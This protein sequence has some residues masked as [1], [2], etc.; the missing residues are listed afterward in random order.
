MLA[1]LR[2]KIEPEVL[3]N[4][5][6]DKLI[7]RSF[8]ND[9]PEGGLY[10][11]NSYFKVLYPYL[12]ELAN[13]LNGQR[14]DL[15]LWAWMI[16]RRFDWTDDARFFDYE[17]ST[18]PNGNGTGKRAI[19]KKFDLFNPDA[20]QKIVGV[21]RELAKK[22][23]QGILIQD[24]LFIRYNEGF[25]NWGKARFTTSTKLPFY[26]NLV[27][28]RDSNFNQDWNRVK[29]NQINKVLE[30]VIA[31]CKQVNP[32]IQIGMNIYYETPFF[33]DRSE[34]WYSHNLREILQTGIDF[35]Y[36]MSYH[37]QMKKEMK[38]GDEQNKAFFKQVVESAY[39]VCGDKLVVKLQLKDWETGDLIPVEEL[40]Q[41]LELVPA[42]VKRVCFM[43][44]GIEDLNHIGQVLGPRSNEAT[45][46][47]V[48]STGE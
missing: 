20:I 28:S 32:K 25:S 26:E 47:A 33:I 11:S 24:D 12:D 30:Q 5:G 6:I 43:P 21:Y 1:D 44:V 38:L 2:G 34:K 4:S 29:I 13:Q 36:L 46:P 39:D 48:E 15:S 22:E 16:G 40:R 23:I 19:I 8:K 9:H 18:Q 42:G 37:R 17:Y 7:V 35:I 41:Y 31:S 3:K 14:G 10:F 27:M 45:I